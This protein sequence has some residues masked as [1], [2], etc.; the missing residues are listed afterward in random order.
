MK[1]P[2]RPA[3]GGRSAGWARLRRLALRTLIMFPLVIGVALF[4][5]LLTAQALYRE[6]LDDFSSLGRIRCALSG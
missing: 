3:N 4:A 1:I 2:N 6:E 5:A